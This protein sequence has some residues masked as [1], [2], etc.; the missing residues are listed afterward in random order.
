MPRALFEAIIYEI[1]YDLIQGKRLNSDTKEWLY[2]TLSIFGLKRK[3]V[4]LLIKRIEEKKIK[5]KVEIRNFLKKLI[6]LR[7][8][9]FWRKPGEL[10]KITGISQ[11]D[12][13]EIL[14][15]LMERGLLKKKIINPKRV[16]YKIKSEKVF[17]LL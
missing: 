8:L 2:S 13:Y 15:E 11:P 6:I 4:N 14:K 7:R 17:E 9:E 10:S 12:M 16:E 3:D 5:T 1:L